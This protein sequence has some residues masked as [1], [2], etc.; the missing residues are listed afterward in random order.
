[1]EPTSFTTEIEDILRV[2]TVDDF[3]VVIRRA[4]AEMGCKTWSSL[5]VRDTE[6]GPKFSTIEDLPANY[7][8]LYND[9]DRSRRDPVMQTIKTSSIPVVWNRAFYEKHGLGDMWEEM[10]PLG[11]RSGITAALHLPYGNHYVLGFDADYDS[12]N[13]SARIQRNMGI[14]QAT[15]VYA[16]TAARFLATNAEDKLVAE[17]VS[18]LKERELQCLQ[19]TAAG[20]TAWEIS[21]IMSLSESSVN[22]CLDKCVVKLM[23]VNKT[24]A[25]AKA[26]RFGVIT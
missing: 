12:P 1:M 4:A 14:L 9:Q 13:D 8:H 6:S 18:T 23:C 19:W 16:E 26:L 11:M 10:A 25:V 7:G 20:K 2:K 22:K 3:K 15:L 21:K 17:Q 24:Q 5:Y